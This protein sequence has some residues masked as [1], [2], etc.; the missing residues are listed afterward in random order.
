MDILLTMAGKYERFKQDGY[1]VPKYLLPWGYQTILAKIISNLD[2][3][4]IKNIYLIA[5]KNDEQYLPHLLDHLKKFN[6]NR[7][8]LIYLSDTSGQAE[9]AFTAINLIKN[10]KNKFCVYNID[11]ILFGRNLVEIEQCLDLND[12]FIDVFKS[13]NKN[14][15]YVLTKNNSNIVSDISEKKIISNVASSG[16]YAFKNYSFFLDFYEKGDIF[17][18]DV[19]KKSIN[20]KSKVI[21]GE[22]FNENNTIVLG[23]PTQYQNNSILML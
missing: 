15:S 5:N 1:K 11:T 2:N 10:Y 22:L 16:M 7:K 21:A 12:I 17:I 9:T 6:I 3:K 18:S 23:T 4:N 19:I 13:N 20:K 8:N 14:Y